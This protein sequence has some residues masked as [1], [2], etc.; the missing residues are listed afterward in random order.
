[1]ATSY[2][3]PVQIQ[4]LANTL[5]TLYTVPASTQTIFSAINICNTASATA[6]FS[7]AFRPNG[8]A[9]NP[10][11]YIIFDAAIAGKDTYMVNQAMSMDEA[12]VLSVI[13]SSASVSFTGFY[14]EVT[15]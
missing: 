8:E 1:M 5:T 13:A 11:H 10:K 7:I 3:S 4:P 14:A 9:I 12:D 15:E 6:T 2:K